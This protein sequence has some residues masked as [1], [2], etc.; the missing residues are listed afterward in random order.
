MRKIMILQNFSRYKTVNFTSFFKVLDQ[1]T[2]NVMNKI[3]L[4][5]VKTK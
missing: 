2:Y 4:G 1:F 3:E 5:L